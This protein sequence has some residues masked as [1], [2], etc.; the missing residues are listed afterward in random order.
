MLDL[1][2]ASTL[3]FKRRGW[4]QYMCVGGRNARSLTG[5]LWAS[6]YTE[7]RVL[8]MLKMVEGPTCHRRSTR[9][10]LNVH[11]LMTWAYSK[12]DL[13]KTAPRWLPRDQPTPGASWPWH[14]GPYGQPWSCSCREVPSGGGNDFHICC[15]NR[16]IHP[17]PPP[18]SI[19][20]TMTPRLRLDLFDSDYPPRASSII[21]TLLGTHEMKIYSSY[22]NEYSQKS[23][24]LLLTTIQE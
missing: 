10:R 9:N 13:T 18:F 15:R 16:P 21:G 8:E 5:W 22:W 17:P 12:T 3:L 23:Y 24:S 20:R 2:P 14:V 4:V 11:T 6:K 19:L 7:Y 1:E